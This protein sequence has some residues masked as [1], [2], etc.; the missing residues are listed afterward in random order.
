MAAPK[1]FIS[2]SWST[3]S[4]E[5]WVLDLATQLAESGIE[6][7]FD[8]WDLREGHDAV[9]FMEKMVTDP[10][11]TKVIMICDKTYS[12][13]ADGRS[14]GVGTE[15]QIISRRVYESTSQDKFVAVVA[16]RD[17]NDSPFIPTYYASRI[18][19][20]LS[21]SER[22]AENFE[23][24]LR[25]VF[26]KPVYVRP[27]IGK[28]PEFVADANA[29]SLGT[30]ALA[31]RAIDSIRSDRG[32]ASGALGEYLS[33]FSANLERLRLSTKDALVDELVV[34]SIDTFAPFRNEFVQ[35]M[36]AYLQYGE[37][38][39]TA[40]SIHR[41]F[42]SLIAY[43]SPPD[44]QTSW[45]HFEFDHFKFVVHELFLYTLSAYL[46]SEDYAS[47]AHLLSEQYYLAKNADRGRNASV[48]FVVVRDNLKSLD[49]RNQN[50]QLNRL[51]LRADF[52]EKRSHSS[53]VPFRNIM[54][55]DFVC[56]M[57]AE[58][59]TAD[60]YDRWWPETL[61]YATRQYGP[62]EVFARAVSKAH[63]ERLL[64][65]LGISS[66][67]PIGV[68]LEEFSS[69]Q[70]SLPR[71]DYESLD[72]RGLMGFEQLGTKA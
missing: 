39:S 38:G 64:P 46:Q 63:L 15:T 61:V 40:R 18:Y 4:H 17:E 20:D 6:V 8:K 68:K 10:A 5:Q 34:N 24:L 47:A 37:P 69:N 2:Y 49:F 66:L 70:R 52:L 42:E 32:Y 53:G 36:S 23:R 56:F 1:L 21:Q 12:E 51:S 33:T 22:Y 57:R 30:S 16:E 54:Q 50:K 59:T 28:P 72:P 65:V 55:A 3:P 48:S 35:V 14:G 9:A 25:W 29:P 67:H 58:L 27:P 60:R 41:F 11:I 26:D 44:T 13:K 45:S 31:R 7:T 62:F 43:Y 19:I 71:W